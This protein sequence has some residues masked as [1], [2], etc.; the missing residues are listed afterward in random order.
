MQRPAGT[1]PPCLASHD[2]MPRAQPEA[3]DFAKPFSTSESF[4]PFDSFPYA[5]P[6]DKERERWLE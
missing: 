3:C 5:H 6:R 1:H 4:E 2:L